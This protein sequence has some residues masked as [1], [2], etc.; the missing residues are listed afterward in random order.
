[1]CTRARPACSACPVAGDCVALATARVAELPA[2]RPRREIPMRETAMLLFVAR[3]SVLLERRPPVGIWGGL[4]SLP[5]ARQEEAEAVA[6]SLGL[7]VLAS[8]PLEPF[9]HRF[10]HF[11]L[12]VQPVL[13]EVD[14]AGLRDPGPGPERRWLP[15]AEA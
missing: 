3:A 14:A 8:R 11:G 5:E 13:L 4:W 9:L 7:D 10:T 6:L 15:L 2:P 1:V 12:R